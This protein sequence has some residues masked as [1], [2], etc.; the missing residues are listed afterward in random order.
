[1]KLNNDQELVLK[2]LLENRGLS[3]HIGSVL[4]AI[5][6]MPENEA[7]SGKLANQKLALQGSQRGIDRRNAKVRYHRDRADRLEERVGKA[8][9]A[10]EPFANFHVA[11]KAAGTTKIEELVSL[12]NNRVLVGDLAKAEHTFNLLSSPLKEP[13]PAELKAAE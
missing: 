8:L 6:A 3:Q 10:L 1:V 4:R 2:I 13:R 12:G 9:E 7:S 11:V 5:E